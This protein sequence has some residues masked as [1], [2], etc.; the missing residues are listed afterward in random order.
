MMQG[1]YTAALG[2]YSQQQRLDTIANNISNVNTLG[3]KNSRA[4]FKDALYRQ[5]QRPEDPQTLNLLKGHGTVVSGFVQS[6]SQGQM[7]DGTETNFYI[8]GQGFFA[9]QN[10][11]GETLYTRD[12]SFVRDN[13]GYLV[14]SG[15][16]Y[17]VLD[18]NGQRIAFPAD[19]QCSTNGSLFI[20]ESETPYTQLQVVDFPNRQ[21][22]EAVSNNMYMVS[23]AS[24]APRA[25]AT[26][27]KIHQNTLEGSNVELADEFS[28]MIR[29]SRI[30]QLCSRALSTADSMD[31]TA[32]N[33]RR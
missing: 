8:E 12:G 22:L 13:D 5:M 28:R 17:Y 3:F 32:I 9:V 1:T 7:M 10:A 31:Q 14:T 11:A 26:D 15:T 2:I 21:G 20:G 18:T 4:D 24:G 16:G 33:S 29:A 23:D 25:A 30:F 27:I 6:F 19:V